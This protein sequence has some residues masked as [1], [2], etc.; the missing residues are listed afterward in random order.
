MTYRVL[1]AILTHP[2]EHGNKHSIR[3]ISRPLKCAAAYRMPTTV[4]S[5]LSSASHP[6]NT[7]PKPR[8]RSPRTRCAQRPPTLTSRAATAPWPISGLAL[9]FHHA[10]ELRHMPGRAYGCN[11]LPTQQA[12]SSRPAS[13]R[14]MDALNCD[15][16]FRYPPAAPTTF[17]ITGF[18]GYPGPQF[19]S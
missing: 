17:G 15:Q 3:V 18:A 6:P 9:R 10:H 12:G 8:Q 14:P 2:R 1:S 5:P 11:G 7:S 4:L 16:T 19:V 13:K